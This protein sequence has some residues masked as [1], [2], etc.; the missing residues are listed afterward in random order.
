MTITP[1]TNNDIHG[2]PKV[3]M[4]KDYSDEP[5]FVFLFIESAI[6]LSFFVA[7]LCMQV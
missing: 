1:T 6:C 5:V 7:I 3:G 4:K 2:D